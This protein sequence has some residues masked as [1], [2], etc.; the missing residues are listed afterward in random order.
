MPDNQE[1]ITGITGSAS[2][3]EVPQFS[4]AEYAHVPGTERCRIC[5]NL[6]SGEYFRVNSQMACGKCAQEARAGQPTDS[7]AAFARGLLFGIGGAIAGLIVYSTFAIVTGWTIGYL[8]LAVGWLVAKAMAKGSNGIG[9]RR[10]QITAVLLTYAAISL[11][12]IPILISYAVKD[13][14]ARTHQSAQADSSD[15][16][17]SSTADD[18]SAS[19]Q[20]S[21][22]AKSINWGA[23]IGQLAFYGIASP[24]L[25][26]KDPAHGIMGLIILF[27]GLSIAYRLTAAKPLDVDGPYSVTG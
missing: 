3:T 12:S 21:E 4:T 23:A 11:A 14:P 1:L 10:Y 24:F 20:S 2:S 7:H 13:R 26:L 8:A 16:S 25:E 18:Q 9:G 15:S 6:I 19:T 5:N 17:D 27:V 22:P